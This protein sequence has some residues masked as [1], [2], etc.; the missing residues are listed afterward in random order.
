MAED[1]MFGWHHDSMDM[2]LSE[3]RELVWT[4]RSGV[5]QSMGSQ[6]L[7]MAETELKNNYYTT[8]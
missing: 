4:E 1:E 2:S 8:K 3:F 7:D 5:L 6:E